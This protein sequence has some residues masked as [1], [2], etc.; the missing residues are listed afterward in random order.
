MAEGTATPTEWW[1]NRL[2][3]AARYGLRLTL[4]ASALLLV[5][6]PFAT[7]LYEV[8]AGGAV[9]RFDGRVADAMND[10]VHQRSA[11]LALLKGLTLFGQFPIEELVVLGAV[12]WLLRRRPPRRRSAVFVVVTAVAG[13]LLDTLVK[14][15]VNRPRPVVDHPVASALGKSFPSG[16]S[17]SSVVVYGSVCLVVRGALPRRGRRWA[18]AG[19]AL[20]I[21]TVGLTRLLLGVHFVSDVVGGF[22]LGAAWLLASSAAFRLW[23]EE[24][25]PTGDPEGAGG[26]TRT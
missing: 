16:H 7:L 22:L 8:K 10:W 15:L 21:V 3:P 26:P 24:D 20:L 25:R 1:R 4:A 5:A 17:M 18:V 14:V 12:V 2:D 11:V 23:L 13:G 19:T 6:V 9:T